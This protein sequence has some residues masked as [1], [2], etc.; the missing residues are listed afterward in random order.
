MTVSKSPAS[1]RVDASIRAFDYE[2]GR[3]HVL[4]IGATAGEQ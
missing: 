4:G 3:F 2:A 1:S